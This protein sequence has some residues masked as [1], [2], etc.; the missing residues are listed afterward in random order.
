MFVSNFPFIFCTLFAPL[1]GETQTEIDFI[2]AFI[3][4]LYFLFYFL[5]DLVL[6]FSDR[7]CGIE[8]TLK[9]SHQNLFCGP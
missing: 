6:L 1:L 9:I 8:L 2:K 4:H 5:I 7:K 3:Y